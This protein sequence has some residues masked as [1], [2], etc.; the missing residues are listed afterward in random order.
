MTTI[1][2]SIVNILISS[3]D[4][5][6]S[7]WFRIGVKVKIIVVRIKVMIGLQL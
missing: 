2:C 7:W 5:V 6:I 3:D 4:T 1:L